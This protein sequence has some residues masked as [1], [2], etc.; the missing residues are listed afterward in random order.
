V[1]SVASAETAVLAG[2]CFWCLEAVFRELEGVI[3]VEPGYSGGGDEAPSY[4]AVCTGTTG[5]AEAVRVVFDPGKLSY[6][7]VLEIFFA[8]HD[9]TT[10]D[11]QG[12][13]VGSQ[14][15]SAVFCLGQN[16]E[17]VARTVVEDLD[18]SGM[19]EA[20]IVTEIVLFRAFHRAEPDHR[21]YYAENPD[22]PY[23]RA[24]ISPKLA[25]FRARFA[26]RLKKP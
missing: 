17:A 9:P 24:V 22:Q 11:R 16:Q 14:Y 15:R 19:F 10:V 20:P 13:D 6:R 26:S 1:N 23:C 25:A 3:S 18:R 4:E 12:A 7:E 8:V 21:D 5:H 2:G